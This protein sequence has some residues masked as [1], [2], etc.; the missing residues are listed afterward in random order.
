MIENIIDSIKNDKNLILRNETKGYDIEA[1]CELSSRAKEIVL[2][3]GLLAF[4][5]NNLK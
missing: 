3:G 4:T 1:S 5:K 2:A